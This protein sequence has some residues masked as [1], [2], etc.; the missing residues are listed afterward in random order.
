MILKNG[1]RFFRQNNIIYINQTRDDFL[2]L[3]ELNLNHMSISTERVSR[4]ITCK[5]FVL[6]PR[7]SVS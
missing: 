5:N 4:D 6:R 2:G 1:E 3:I 7:R